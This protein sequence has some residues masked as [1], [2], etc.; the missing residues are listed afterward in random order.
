M[1]EG[2]EMALSAGQQ[3]NAA[4]TTAYAY[5]SGNFNGQMAKALS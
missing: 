4:Q 3:A 1:L 2:A 5:T